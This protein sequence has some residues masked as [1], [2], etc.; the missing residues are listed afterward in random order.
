MC[1]PNA[2]MLNEGTADNPCNIIFK[3]SDVNDNAHSRRMA[4]RFAGIIMTATGLLISII[5]VAIALLASVL[6]RDKPKGI[7]VSVL[8]WFILR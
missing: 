5:F 2:K 8:L 7:S 1:A 6:T 3:V 4:L